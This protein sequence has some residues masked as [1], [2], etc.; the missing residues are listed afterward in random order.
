MVSKISIGLLNLEPL[1][2]YLS[3]AC[4]TDV[5]SKLPEFLRY[6]SSGE[7]LRRA[8]GVTLEEVFCRDR[9]GSELW[10]TE[11]W[12]EENILTRSMYCLPMVS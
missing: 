1:Q 10:N 5:C 12:G 7:L 8:K 9:R 3:K 11:D 6:L 2:S 4:K